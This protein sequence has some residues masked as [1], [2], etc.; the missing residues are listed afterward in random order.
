VTA[1]RF[2][3]PSSLAPRSANSIAGFI[4]YNAGFS[5]AFVFLAGCAF[6]A[7]LLL[8]I[9]MPETGDQSDACGGAEHPKARTPAG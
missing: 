4:V 3:I 5:A 7:L 1:R 9:A 2:P 8:W 6:A